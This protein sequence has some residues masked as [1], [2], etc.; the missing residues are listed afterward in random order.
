MSKKRT[1]S[2]GKK[3][4]KIPAPR[5]PSNDHGSIC[6]F[7]THWEGLLSWMSLPQLHCYVASCW[8]TFSFSYST[9]TRTH[10]HAHTHT[11]TASCWSTFS[12]SYNTCTHTHCKLLEHF[13][14]LLQ[15]T[16]T[17][18]HTHSTCTH[19]PDPQQWLSAVAV[20]ETDR[21]LGSALS[22]SSPCSQ[23]SSESQASVGFI[24]VKCI[25]IYVYILKGRSY[26]RKHFSTSSHL[27]R[28]NEDRA[29]AC[30]RGL[31]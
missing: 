14:F 30:L 4:T 26:F 28:K 6:S 21:S 16:H 19:C 5:I 25:C 10:T 18:T 29:S 2:R 31:P 11:T 27:T 23:V 12:F 8:S 17:H 22:C 1:I 7:V 20:K 15:H 9:H 3:T 24:W 13:F